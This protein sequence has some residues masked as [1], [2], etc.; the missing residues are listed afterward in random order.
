MPEGLTHAVIPGIELLVAAHHRRLRHPRF[1]GDLLDQALIDQSPAQPF[2]QAM[3]KFR[4]AAA[5]LTFYG[6]DSDHGLPLK[7]GAFVTVAQS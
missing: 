1:F 7:A 3:R 6:D 2:G 4:A 5:I